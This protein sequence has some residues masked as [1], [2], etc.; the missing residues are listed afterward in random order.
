MDSQP[1]E[2]VVFAGHLDYRGLSVHYLNKYRRSREPRR[3]VVVG[4]EQRSICACLS[5]LRMFGESVWHR[6][7]VFEE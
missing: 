6:L 2:E 1:L 7:V 3:T 5:A 4:G